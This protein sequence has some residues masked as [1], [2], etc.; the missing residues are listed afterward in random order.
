MA[1]LL[2]VLRM[3][4]RKMPDDAL[5]RLPP[6]LQEIHKSRNVDHMGR[7]RGV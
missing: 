3:M 5:A 4:A 1:T 2:H 6:L 7:G